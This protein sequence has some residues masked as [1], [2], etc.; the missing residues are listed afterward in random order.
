MYTA[1]GILGGVLLVLG[2][3]WPESKKE[4]P[5]Y[6][7]PK[8]LI[9]AGGGLF[10]LFYTL[11]YILDDGPL[12]FLFLQLFANLGAIFMLLD[13]DDRIDTTV[14]TLGGLLFMGLSLW[15][16]EDLTT[17]YFIAGLLGV[18]LGYVIHR[19]SV[20]RQVAFFFG[21]ALITYY[22]CLSGSWIFFWLNVFFAVFSLMYIILYFVRPRD[23]GD[24]HA[25]R[26]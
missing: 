25:H 15:F 9:L 2:S 10:M 11:F 26:N 14:M 3:A 24:A 12:F 23:N 22:S 1:L 16:Y 13:V 19:G 8:S 4:L 6:A 7:E 21:S 20:W 18:G 17:L 5:S